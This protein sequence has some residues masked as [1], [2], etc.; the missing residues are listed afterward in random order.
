LRNIA[1]ACGK[2]SPDVVLELLRGTRGGGERA[3]GEAAASGLV[4]DRQLVDAVASRMSDATIAGFVAR[5]VTSG[6]TPTDRLAMA[7]Q[8]LVPIPGDRQRLLALAREDVAESPLGA[9]GDF[10]ATWDRVT[11]QL[12]Q[13]YS[14]E[15]FV[16]A[17]YGRELSGARE[18]A[19]E[20]E[21]MH[22]DP[23]DRIRAW[24]GSVATTALRSLDLTLVADLLRIETDETHW[25]ELMIPVVRLLEDLFLVG[26]FEGAAPL[27]ELLV[28]ETAN[29]AAA[30]RGPHAG[31]AL[32]ALL[33]G[34]AIRHIATHLGTT[35][36]VQVEAIRSVC[37]AIG[38]PVV[39]PLVDALCAEDRPATR[40]QLTA[41]LAA[42][43]P[44]SRRVVE[45]LKASP[46][47]GLRRTAMYLLRRF[48]GSDSL[49]AAAELL[50]TADPQGQREALRAILNVG[51]DAGYQIV[52]QAL[53]SAAPPVR[54]TII[55]SICSVRDERATPMFAF[56]LRH[57]DRR[58]PLAALFA[59][60]IDALGAL[61]DPAAIEP[62]TAVLYDGDWW[63]PRRT[64]T[65]RAAAAAALARIGSADARETLER[66]A[67][68]G[69]RGVQA[70][71]RPH[72]SSQ[73]PD[74]AR[75][76]EGRA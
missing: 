25:G 35:D 33:R 66:A 50:N 49:P 1:S 6:N 2:L 40:E 58:G 73:H 68:T 72:V 29:E 39:Q 3:A 69:P 28:R 76:R 41:I 16:S 23:P 57:V 27:V 46:D 15:P 22:E 4:T 9:T 36:E 45:Q 10:A 13:S 51:S 64:A 30:G 62:L 42:F 14:D 21:S 74:R 53:T 59:R 43:G 44:V 65:L 12:L 5:H 19:V 75:L 63:T 18:R 60:S 71:A 70:A 8:A 67:T 20:V 31:A 11:E 48:G 24:I 7:F 32:D 34:P 56:F 26:D 55:H 17:D 47:A 37:V 61:R 54:E 38:A 52:E